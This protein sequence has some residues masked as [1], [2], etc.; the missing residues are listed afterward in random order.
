METVISMMGHADI[1]VKAVLIILVLSSIWSWTVIFRK[2]FSIRRE[3]KNSKTY[4][5]GFWSGMADDNPDAM[6]H[7]NAS[8][9]VFSAA[10]RDFADARRGVSNQAQAEALIARADT[11]MRTAVDREISEKGKGIGVLAIVG[12]TAPF[13]GL[14][15]T[16][17]GILIAMLAMAERED[18]S[19]ATVAPALAEALVATG[20]GLVVAI[21]AV[22]FYNIFTGDLNRLADQ[23]DAFT[24]DVI[25]RLSRQM[26]GPTPKQG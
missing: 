25:V 7:K 8:G 18:S 10:S 14:F 24:Q 4:E 19:F 21:P 2:F 5:Q 12:S 22:V 17:W 26:T 9:R 3:I 11:S 13:I 1:V 16:V 6:V 15:G 23:L 20:A